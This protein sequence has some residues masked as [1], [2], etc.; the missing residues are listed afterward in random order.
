MM[1]ERITNW[2]DERLETKSIASAFLDRHIP[3]GVGWLYTLGSASLFIFMMQAVTGIFLSMNYAP[4]PDHAYDS[5]QYINN[6]VT[7]GWFVRRLHQWGASGMV[8]IV[9]AHMLRVFFMGAYKYPRE[10]TWVVGVLIFLIVMGFGFTGYL[11]PWDQKA[12]WATAVGTNVAGSLPYVG[13][14]VLKVLRGGSDLGAVTLTRF[15]AI[16]MLILP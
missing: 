11:L 12:Y 16:H 4:S 10:L 6:S 13:T 15:Y 8:V 9:A 7:F 2:V 14:F 5:I 3:K 1:W